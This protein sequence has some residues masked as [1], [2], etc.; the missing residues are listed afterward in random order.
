[1]FEQFQSTFGDLSKSFGGKQQ[2]EPNMKVN[3]D[4]TLSLDRVAVQDMAPKFNA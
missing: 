4:G 3:M 2:P 1:M